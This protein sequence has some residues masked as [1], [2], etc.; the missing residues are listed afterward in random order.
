MQGLQHERSFVP[1]ACLVPV[2]IFPRCAPAAKDDFEAELLAAIAHRTVGEADLPRSFFFDHAARE[3]LRPLCYVGDYQTLT[4][5]TAVFA[6]LGD[7][8][9][10]IHLLAKLAQ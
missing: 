2:D 8:G 3:P 7:S 9:R 1:E 10:N 4:I 5:M 6:I